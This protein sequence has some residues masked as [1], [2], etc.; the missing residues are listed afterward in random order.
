[1]LKPKIQ[2]QKQAWLRAV[3]KEVDRREAVKER[4]ASKEET[5][6]LHQC[7]IK[8]IAMYTQGI[9]LLTIVQCFLAVGLVYMLNG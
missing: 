4:L 6:T 2:A 7:Y 1:M 8:D 9:W 3:N 5:R